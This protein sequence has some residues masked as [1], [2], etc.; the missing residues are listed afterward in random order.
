MCTDTRPCIHCGDPFHYRP[1]NPTQTYCSKPACQRARK[2]RWEREK[3][4]HDPDYKSN[5]R[6]AQKRWQEKKPDYWKQWRENNPDYVTRN[7]EQQRVRNAKLRNPDPADDTS[8]IAKMDLSGLSDAPTEAIALPAGDYL[9]IPVDC[10][11]GRVD[12]E[13]HCKIS[14]LSAPG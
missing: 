6:N 9:L 11:G 12:L 5:Q 14:P 4:C 3:C 10:K 8:T 2:T 1:Q 13:Y 7:R